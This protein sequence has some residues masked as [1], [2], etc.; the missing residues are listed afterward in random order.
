MKKKRLEAEIRRLERRVD[1]LTVNLG[2][3]KFNTKRRLAAE[4]EE[5]ISLTDEVREIRKKRLSEGEIA[6][7]ADRVYRL[8]SRDR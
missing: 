5:F 7:V 2:A 8:L 6:D 3:H 1:I 4:R